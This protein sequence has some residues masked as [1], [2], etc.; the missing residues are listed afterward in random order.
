MYILQI[1]D[2]HKIVVHANKFVQHV[3]CHK[4]HIVLEWRKGDG[5]DYF[6]STLYGS[7]F[8]RENEVRGAKSLLIQF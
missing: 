1:S 3:N 8:L 6:K 7:T 5:R 2:D 4:I